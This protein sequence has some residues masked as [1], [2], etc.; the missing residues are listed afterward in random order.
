MDNIP[1]WTKTAGIW[2]GIAGAILL[3]NTEAQPFVV[4]TLGA[5]ILVMG[6][7]AVKKAGG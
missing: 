6:Y 2:I 7:Q 1:N 3:S 4:A 5:V